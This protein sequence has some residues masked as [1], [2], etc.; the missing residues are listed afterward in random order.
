VKSWASR[1]SDNLKI[2]WKNENLRLEMKM[3]ILDYVHHHENISISSLADYTNQEYIL[4]AAVVEELRDEGLI[5][6][7]KNIPG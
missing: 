1:G 6:S 7:K 2:K 4:V 3:N 5:P